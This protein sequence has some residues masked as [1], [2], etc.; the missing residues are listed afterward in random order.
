MSG[1]TKRGIVPLKFKF[2]IRELVTRWYKAVLKSHGID[3]SL[4]DQKKGKGASSWF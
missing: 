2:L 3:P 4:I 1:T